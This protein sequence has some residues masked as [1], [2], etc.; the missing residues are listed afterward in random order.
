ME[1]R[2]LLYFMSWL[3]DR[4]ERDL[5]VDPTRVMHTH[6]WVSQSALTTTCP[7]Y[8]PVSGLASG[9]GCG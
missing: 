3:Q 2:P 6:D 8:G 5:P 9:Q 7:I 1:I 4:Y